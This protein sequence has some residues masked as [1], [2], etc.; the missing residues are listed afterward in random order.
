MPGKALCDLDSLLSCSSIWSKVFSAR[1]DLPLRSPVL[2]LS[3]GLGDLCSSLSLI[4]LESVLGNDSLDSDGSPR[5]CGLGDRLL[6]L[7]SF[8]SLEE[9]FGDP[10][11]VPLGERPLRDVKSS[12]AQGLVAS[13]AWRCT[14]VT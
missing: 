8:A 12:E 11:G 1:G 13:D 4:S 14:A 9:P 3:S 5:A 10:R 2:A 7:P 6:T